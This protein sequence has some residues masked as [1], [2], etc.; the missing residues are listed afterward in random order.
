MISVCMA[1]YNGARFVREQLESILSQLPSD[2]EVI[3]A[4]DG[5]TD[6][7]Q[8]IILAVGDERIRLLPESPHLGPILN[9]ERALKEARGEVIF[10]SDQDDIWVPGKVQYMLEALGFDGTTFA[11][12]APLLAVHDAIFIDGDGEPLPSIS[13][14]FQYQ[15]MWSKRPYKPGV[16]H[17][18]MKNSFTGCCMAFRKDLLKIALPFPK[19]LPMHDQWLGLLAERKKSVAEVPQ[20]LILYRIHENNATQLLGGKSHGFAQRLKWRLNLLWTLLSRIRKS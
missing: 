3:V 16:S 2:A 8:K 12:N 9:F 14:H 13:R 1:T 4:D 17:N 7:T 10:L 20:S 11:T 19:N 5:S 6:E 18:W 15:T